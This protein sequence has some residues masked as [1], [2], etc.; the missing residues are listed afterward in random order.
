MKVN[1]KYFMK[2][3]F[4]WII[5]IINLKI[6]F[7]CRFFYEY[8]SLMFIYRFAKS[9]LPEFFRIANKM[10]GYR[11]TQAADVELVACLGH[12]N[13]QAVI[14]KDINVEFADGVSIVVVDWFILLIWLKTMHSSCSQHTIIASLSFGFCSRPIG[15]LCSQEEVWQ[16]ILFL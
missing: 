10:F 15:P 11:F 1:F 5:I 16:L 13:K 9:P 6:V 8:A 4:K 12:V 3:K 7:H 2:W 14:H